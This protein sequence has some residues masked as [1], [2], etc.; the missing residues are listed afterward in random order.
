MKLTK[1]SPQRPGMEGEMD[2]QK[3]LDALGESARQTRSEYHLTLG[4]LIETLEQQDPAARVEVDTSGS[5]GDLTS[6]RGYYADLAF[7]PADHAT[8]DDVVREA[9]AARGATFVGYKGGDFV[10]GADTPLWIAEWGCCGVAIVGI[11]FRD[12]AVV[13]ETKEIE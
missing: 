11:E 7:M 6:Y 13:L 3:L 8:V 4:K 1:P 9:R 2:I 10:M 5:V 12:G